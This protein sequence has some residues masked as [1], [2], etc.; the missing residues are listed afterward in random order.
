MV[1]DL[2]SGGEHIIYKH[3]T[4]EIVIIHTRKY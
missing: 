1:T 2:F 3:T 4:I